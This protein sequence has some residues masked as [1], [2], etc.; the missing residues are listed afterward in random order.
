MEVEP[1]QSMEKEGAR[2]G[3]RMC[4]DHRNGSRV[5]ATQKKLLYISSFCV[6]IPL[7]WHARKL[8]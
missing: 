5:R 8:F 3:I 2:R 7:L 6:F 1:R 4:V